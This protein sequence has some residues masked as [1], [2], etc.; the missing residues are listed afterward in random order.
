MRIL[1]YFFTTGTLSLFFLNTVY[2]TSWVDLKP[3]EVIERSSVIVQGKYDFSKKIKGSN[4]IWVG[5]NFTVEQ[6]YKGNVT[7]TIIAGID[8]FDIGWVDEIQQANGSFVLFLEQ[9]EAVDFLTPVGGPNGM[10]HI[11]NSE[12][13]HF[14][15]KK[16]ETFT[17][18]LKNTKSH[19]PDSSKQEDGIENSTKLIIGLISVIIVLFV[20]YMVYRN[21]KHKKLDSNSVV[22]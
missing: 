8:G 2:A 1:K 7:D 15:E 12:V 18:Y 14:D 21:I 9:T 16:R 22:V 10:I 3:E 13:Q 17:D 19:L 11:Q 4:S 20:L 5:Y 6:V